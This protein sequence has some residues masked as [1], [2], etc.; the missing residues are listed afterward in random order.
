MKK[1]IIYLMIMFLFATGSAGGFLLLLPFLTK[2]FHFSLTQAGIIGGAFSFSRIFSVI[3]LTMLSGKIGSIPMLLIA[4][5]MYCLG[6]VSVGFQH[7]FLIFVLL[8]LLV[9]IAISIFQPLVFGLSTRLS[10]PGERGRVMGFV[11][12]GSDLGRIG[13]AGALS[14]AATQLGW[15]IA[16]I[17]AGCILLIFLLCAY[18][19]RPQIKEERKNKKTSL[20]HETK[21]LTK[22]VQFLLTSGIVFFDSIASA[23]LFVYLPFLMIYRHISLSLMP[24]L[25][26]IFFFGSLCGKLYLGRLTDKFRNTLV[27]I[28]AES[29]MAV[30]LIVI[31]NITS[32]IL[33][34]GISFI[35]GVLTKGTV[36]ASLTMASESVKDTGNFEHAY[37]VNYIVLSIANTITPVIV[38]FVAD[39]SN[40]TFSFYFCA[41]AAFV[42]TIP[43]FLFH[44]NR[45]KRQLEQALAVEKFIS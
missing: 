8:F 16:S 36:P 9:G 41:L 19:K 33:F 7:F 23:T 35:L 11:T 12:S 43:A 4:T 22:N 44:Q 38:G 6:F 32:P 30:F 37:A 2:E 18:I 14:F 3:P 1:E 10:E 34:A 28:S 31:A 15:R 40:I 29:L 5:G 21:V 39:H 24:F 45:A 17:G 20:L 26:A 25:I 27:F 13:I 42:A